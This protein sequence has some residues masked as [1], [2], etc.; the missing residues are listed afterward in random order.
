VGYRGRRC[1]SRKGCD[2]LNRCPL[3]FSGNYSF[4]RNVPGIWYETM[5]M[6]RKRTSPLAGERRCT[7]SACLRSLPVWH[8]HAKSRYRLAWPSCAN[9]PPFATDP[10]GFRF[11]PRCQLGTPRP[12]R[13]GPR[14]SARPNIHEDRNGISIAAPDA[15]LN[16]T[17]RSTP[18]ATNCS[19]SDFVAAGAKSLTP[20]RGGANA[21]IALTAIAPA[22]FED[23]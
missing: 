8:R 15:Y 22:D 10:S 1:G 18:A 19:T 7:R 9:S 14:S 12:T 11:R 3:F 2:R 6:I 16:P 20:I 4:L 13:L 5:H 23:Q 17:I 21:I